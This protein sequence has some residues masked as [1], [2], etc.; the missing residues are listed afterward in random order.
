MPQQPAQTLNAITIRHYFRQLGLTEPVLIHQQDHAQFMR[1]KGLTELGAGGEGTVYFTRGHV[2]KVIHAAS[3]WGSLR[4]VAH[5][6]HLNRLSTTGDAGTMG[7]R[8][9]GDWPALVWIYILSNGSLAIGMKPFDAP[10]KPER[11]ATLFERLQVGPGLSRDQVQYLLLSLCDSLHFAHQH[12]ILHHDLKPAN[13]YVPSDPEARPVIFDL[14]QALWQQSSWG[15]A[16][17]RHT[18]NHYYWYNGTY[19]YMQHER[20]LAHLAALARAAGKSPTPAQGEAFRNFVPAYYDDIFS[21]ARI[22][23]DIVQSQLVR[24]TLR[25]RILL[26]RFYRRLMG[27]QHK[28]WQNSN[29]RDSSSIFRRVI[30]VLQAPRSDPHLSVPVQEQYRSMSQVE[31]D[32][33][34][35]LRDME[36]PEPTQGP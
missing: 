27:L 5:M 29:T 17:L 12:G 2:V 28:K 25:D 4:E 3:A 6:L 8:R 16:W 35:V 21:F 24:L 23:R 11:G 30:G 15:R 36:E 20:R 31:S 18:H 13:I 10:D 9:R 26:R 7:D 14:G 22:V 32:L 19:R 34:G 1:E 33:E